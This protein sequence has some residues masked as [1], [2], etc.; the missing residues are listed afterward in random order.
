MTKD[1][2]IQQEAQKSDLFL[3]LKFVNPSFYKNYIGEV[4]E[5]KNDELKTAA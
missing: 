2:Y 5:I 1:E 3:F 4:E